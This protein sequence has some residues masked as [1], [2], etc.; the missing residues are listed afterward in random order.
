MKDIV[1]LSSFERSIKKLTYQDRKDLSE[2]LEKFNRFLLT[3]ELVVGLGFKK[4]NHDKFEFRI[5]IKLR[6]VF[7]QSREAIY[8]V[9][10]GNHDEVRKYLK[11]YRSS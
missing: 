1:V 5:N 7:K 2:A 6:V 10:V 9:L 4:I 11:N 3:G 8:L